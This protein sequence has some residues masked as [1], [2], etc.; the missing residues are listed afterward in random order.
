MFASCQ[1]W[2]F[3]GVYLKSSLRLDRRQTFPAFSASAAQDFSSS[4]GSGA[5]KEA[6]LI[7]SFSFGRLIGSLHSVTL[8]E[9][10]YF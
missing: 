4:L 3:S 1:D 2:T 7:A 5:G 8:S 9:T 10:F 6:V